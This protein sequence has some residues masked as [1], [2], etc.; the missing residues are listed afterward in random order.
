[1]PLPV[2]RKARKGS[3]RPR[4]AG[5]LRDAANTPRPPRARPAA[6]PRTPPLTVALELESVLFWLEDEVACLGSLVV[7]LFFFLGQ[8]LHIGICGWSCGISRWV[9]SGSMAKYRDVLVNCEKLE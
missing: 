7:L 4:K 9:P 5:Y 2:I 1:M 8:D 3:V 6:P